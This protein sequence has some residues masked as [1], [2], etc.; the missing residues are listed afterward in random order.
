[1]MT[2]ITTQHREYR[3]P[4]LPRTATL[5]RSATL[6]ALLFASVAAAEKPAWAPEGSGDIF[7]TALAQDKATKGLIL[8]DHGEGTPKRTTAAGVAAWIASRPDGAGDGYFHLVVDTSVKESVKVL[9]DS[10][11]PVLSIQF[12]DVAA[13]NVWVQYDS[14]DATVVNESYPAGV[15]KM[16][17][18]WSSG[19]V[20]IG[21]G[22]LKTVCTRLPMLSATKRCHGADI[23]INSTGVP[24]FA[25]VGISLS[26]S[27]TP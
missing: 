26:T 14:T 8:L 24:G 5:L 7:L 4:H 21:D 12:A 16:P 2:T 10:D 19:L 3:M 25:I 6:A 1:M 18:A 23:R 22:K 9:A 11:G 15:W 27:T 13:G 20:C 17:P